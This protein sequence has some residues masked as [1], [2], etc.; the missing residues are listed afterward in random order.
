MAGLT[1]QMVQLS[2][3]L[4]LPLVA[5]NDVHYLAAEDAEIQDILECISTNATI[6]DAK[7]FRMPGDSFYFKTGDEMAA[8]FPELPDAL[9]NTRVIADACNLSLD[10]NRLHLPTVVVPEGVDP[11]EYLTKTCWEALRRLY[12]PMTKEAEERLT[13]ELDVIEKT[14]FSLYMM[15]VADFVNYARS[16]D[17]YFGIRG[18]AAGSIVCY[19]LGITDLDPLAWHLAFERF[20]NTE[21]KNMPDI[22]MDFA[23]DRRGEMIEYVAN[24]YGYDRVAQIITFGTLGAKAA[25]RDVGRVLGYPINEV[26]RIAK[27][28]PRTAG[29]H[30]A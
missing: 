29:R 6:D 23:D 17:I 13:Y 10:F 15:I 2:K 8:L 11:D 18:S 25:L 20:L 19:C 30:H 9:R 7:R 27:M 22:D 4:D 24:R 12:T 1:A 21:R 14:G 28:V 3:E 16:H 5:T 26:D